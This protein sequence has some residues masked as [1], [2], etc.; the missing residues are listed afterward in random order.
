MEN[1]Q[2]RKSMYMFNQ[3]GHINIHFISWCSYRL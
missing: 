3:A 1:L 2:A